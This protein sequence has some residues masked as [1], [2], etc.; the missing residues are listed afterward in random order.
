M[1]PI[2]KIQHNSAGLL[3]SGLLTLLMG[4]S[5]LIDT[6][7]CTNSGDCAALARPNQVLICT[8]ANLCEEIP[9]AQCLADSDCGQGERCFNYR[10]GEDVAANNGEPVNNGEAPGPVAV[11]GSITVDTTWG[12]GQTYRMT[13]LVL[14]EAGATLTIEAG[15]TVLGEQGSALVVKSGGRLAARGNQAR[16]IVFTSAQPVGQRQ[17]GDWGGVTLLGQARANEPNALF[18][19]LPPEHAAYGGN[20]DAWNCG[21]MQYVRV[22]FA[23][24]AVANNKELNALTLA[25]CGSDT[26]L[27]HIQ[28]HRGKDDGLEFFGGT[29]T[30]KHILI[31]R[32]QDDSLDWDR[33]WRG[34][35]QFLAVQQDAEGENGIEADNWEDDPNAIPRSAP[36]ICNATFIGDRG[37]R[38]Q[39][40]ALLRRGT[41]GEISN[42][43][44]V[45]Y[46]LYG[47][48]IHGAETAQQATNGDLSVHHSLFYDIG[49][50]GELFFPLEE[51]EGDDAGLD[52]GAMFADAA[53]G[54]LFGQDP[55]LSDPFNLRSPGLVPPTGSVVEG[56]GIVPN[57]DE[58]DSS[59]RYLGAF[60]PGETPWTAGWTAYDED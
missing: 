41:A 4:C 44:F 52:E 16:P 46:R 58:F 11:E 60:A 25:G 31:T 1:N 38:E 37:A 36:T 15:V 26:L 3:A 42:S 30:G 21:V 6:Q 33:G 17:P 34:G 22:E 10:C 40:G 5:A 23:G 49:D 59:A 18:E 53:M 27:D 55:D 7:E 12:E 54:N 8:S 13:S 28:I 56:A 51:G 29:A 48:N 50:S 24:F 47:I 32:A 57:E 14:V 39:R 35:I 19:A 43:V 9:G 45:G 20:N 2:N